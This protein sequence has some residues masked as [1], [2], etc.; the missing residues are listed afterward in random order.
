MYYYLQ[1]QHR[2]IVHLGGNILWFSFLAKWNL[3][4]FFGE[5]LHVVRS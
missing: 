5:L 3:C 2:N 4:R 1:M